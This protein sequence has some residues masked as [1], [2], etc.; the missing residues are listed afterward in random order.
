MPANL[1]SGVYTI[2]VSNAYIAVA[3]TSFTLLTYPKDQLV[4]STQLNQNSYNPLDTVNGIVKVTLPNGSLFN[5]TLTV[6]YYVNYTNS[7]T[8]NTSLVLSSRG[9][10]FFSFVVPRNVGSLSATIFFTVRAL[11]LNHTQ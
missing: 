1:S 7:S 9:D 10:A 8:A 4:V 6:N 3:S 5:T 2:K 11:S